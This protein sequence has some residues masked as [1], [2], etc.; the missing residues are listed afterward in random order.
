VWTR[1]RRWNPRKAATIVPAISG[2]PVTTFSNWAQG[3]ATAMHELEQAIRRS[4]P[5]A[6]KRVSLRDGRSGWCCGLLQRQRV[7]SAADVSV[8]NLNCDPSLS[9]AQLDLVAQELLPNGHPSAWGKC[10]KHEEWPLDPLYT[11]GR[12]PY[13]GDLELVRFEPISAHHEDMLE[14]H[15]RGIRTPRAR[16]DALQFLQNP[17]EACVRWLSRLRDHLGFGWGA[18]W[19]ALAEHHRRPHPATL[20]DLLEGVGLERVLDSL[21]MQVTSQRYVAFHMRVRSPDPLWVIRSGWADGAHRPE[22]A[23]NPAPGEGH[24][25][26]LD[27][28]DYRA[29]VPEYVFWLRPRSALAIDQDATVVHGRHGRFE[30][31]IFSFDASN[32]TSTSK[33]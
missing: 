12:V 7:A 25:R 26:A 19:P 4:H 8:A 33:P 16:F 27:L 31:V 21:G 29:Y 13:S 23:V 28:R 11:L 3:D 9:P 24:G 32:A 22:F 30:V 2:E 14:L 1:R 17:G 15:P 20:R 5:V 18:A 6:A 10:F